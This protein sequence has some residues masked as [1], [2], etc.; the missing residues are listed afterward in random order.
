MKEGGLCIVLHV[1]VEI[2]DCNITTSGWQLKYFQMG[3]KGREICITGVKKRREKNAHAGGRFLV[4]GGRKLSM[5]MD[6]HMRAI[7]LFYG[8]VVAKHVG[9]HETQATTPESI[10]ISGSSDVG[11]KIKI[12]LS[13]QQPL[14]SKR[15]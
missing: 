12:R 7:K 3:G 6:Q 2:E 4:N 10:T 11:V 8:S 15:A 13:Q 9:L 1:G 5:R 14:F